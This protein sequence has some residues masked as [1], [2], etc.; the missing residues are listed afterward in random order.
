MVKEFTKSFFVSAG[1]ANAQHLL[2]VPQ[3][4][5]KLIDIATAHANSLGIGNPNMPDPDTG[6]V[7]SRLTIDMESFPTVNS[8]YSITTWV[9]GWNRHFSLRCFMITDAEGR[10]IGYARSIW[11]ILNT[12]NHANAGLSA[13]LFPPELISDR[14]CPIPKQAKHEKIGEGG[15]QP[16]AP[17][18]YHTFKY[19]DL[20]SYRHVNTV[21]YVQLLLNQLPLSLYDKMSLLRL[22]LSFLHEAA[23]DTEV[24]INR[25]QRDCLYSFYIEGPDQLQILYA[26]L[27]FSPIG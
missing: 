13:L 10:T 15:L 16:T 21:R 23:Y 27:A 8:S 4:T 24:T 26:R 5:A 20:D 3:L 6:W 11:M 14:P 18:T 25:H 2:S 12:R 7:L 19:C 1:E 9:E 17:A 22:E